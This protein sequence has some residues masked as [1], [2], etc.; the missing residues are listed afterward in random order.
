MKIDEKSTLTSKGHFSGEPIKTNGFSMIFRFLAIEVGSKNGTKFNQKLH[1][2]LEAS[3]HRF[4]EHFGT[5][6][7]ALG[8]QNP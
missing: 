6:W 2:T 8:A 4:F 3:W 1:Q 7:V 5:T